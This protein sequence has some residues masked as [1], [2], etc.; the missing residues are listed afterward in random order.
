[1]DAVTGTVTDTVTVYVRCPR[2]PPSDVHPRSVATKFRPWQTNGPG[3]S[4]LLELI[5][6]YK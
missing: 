6:N 2:A 1:M 3:L 4:G 5:L